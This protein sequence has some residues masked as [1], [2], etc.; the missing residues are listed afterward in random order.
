MSPRPATGAPGSGAARAVAS[1]ARPDPEARAVGPGVG[2]THPHGLV[3]RLR[4]TR[5][6][7]LHR[8]VGVCA[9]LVAAVV[10][11]LV[12]GV[13]AGGYALPVGDV[14]A[15][16]TG[17][18]SRAVRFVVLDLRLPRA[19]LALLVGGALGTAGALFQGALRNP[20]ASPDLVG[21]TPGASAAAVVAAVHLGAGGPALSAA[22]LGGA[23]CTAAVVALLARG[24]GLSGPRL[25]LVGVG[26]G[27]ALSGVVSYEMTDS[28]VSSAQDA[29]VWLSGSLNDADPGQVRT[30]LVVL[31]V[32]LP[33]VVAL[34]R[35]VDVL[36][37]GD[38]AARGL[39]VRPAVVRMTALGA[40]VVLTGA[41][42]AAAGP[43]GF[44]SFVAAPVARRLLP[45]RGSVPLT[46]GLV[47]AV[48]VGG[49]DL[50]AHHLVWGGQV[51][52]GL[53]TSLVGAPYLLW[54]LA[55]STRA[56]SL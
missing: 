4:R 37:L 10:C 17:G 27:G 1:P 24:G 48:L 26:V 55:R 20:L 9:A 50:V 44:V 3:L 25:V 36:G 21:I 40:G 23:L 12:V 7:A 13:C 52:V 31:V 51:P 30:V 38:D 46:S 32:V 53:I 2:G 42:V 28:R 11:C 15:A 6:R 16:L 56:G 8:A 35:A 33:V 54:L 45:G 49:S 43:V 41:A 14:L 5:R 39:G 47:G 29:L 19:A 34:T 22:A 18:G